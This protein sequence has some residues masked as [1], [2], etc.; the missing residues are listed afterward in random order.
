MIHLKAILKITSLGFVFALGLV[1]FVGC[2][3]N[4]AFD[5]RITAN[6]AKIESQLNTDALYIYEDISP[7][8]S[9]YENYFKAGNYLT[10]TDA[11]TFSY[12]KYYNLNVMH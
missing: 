11:H 3:G 6:D 12:V 4:D 10:T 1:L 5:F 9:P 7:D 8:K 2:S